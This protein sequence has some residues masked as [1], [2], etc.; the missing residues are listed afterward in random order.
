MNE[1]TTWDEISV[2]SADN[3]DILEADISEQSKQRLIE[4]NKKIILGM[5]K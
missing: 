1:Y 2:L 5:L 3:R 4:I